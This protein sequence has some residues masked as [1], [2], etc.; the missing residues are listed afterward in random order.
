MECA[1]AI[2]GILRYRYEEKRELRH[3]NTS[4]NESGSDGGLVSEPVG[5]FDCIKHGIWMSNKSFRQRRMGL[6]AEVIQKDCLQIQEKILLQDFQDL[7][8]PAAI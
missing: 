3:L 6:S 8:R 1:Q 5:T 4:S 7:C 2:K